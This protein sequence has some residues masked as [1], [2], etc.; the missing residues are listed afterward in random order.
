MFHGFV[1]LNCSIFLDRA[2]GEA[3]TVSTHHQAIT[4]L[5]RDVQG[6]STAGKQHQVRVL[7]LPERAQHGQS[8]SK[9]A[10][11]P[12]PRI[13]GGRF[14]EHL[15]ALSHDSFFL[16][17]SLNNWT[18]EPKRKERREE[19]E[20]REDLE[21]GWGEGEEDREGAG[22]EVGGGG[23]EKKQSQKPSP[24]TSPGGTSAQAGPRAGIACLLLPTSFSSTTN[25]DVFIHTRPS[26]APWEALN[27]HR[28]FHLCFCELSEELIF[29]AVA[30]PCI[31]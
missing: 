5:S 19:E 11:R 16:N 12:P 10:K 8:V 18:E 4:Y 7:D 3:L 31:S 2:A 29:D 21:G 25:T 23:A 17:S 15:F 20:E 27:S 28:P 6:L 24:R 9:W 26:W 14:Y 1:L 22:L 13:E 30:G